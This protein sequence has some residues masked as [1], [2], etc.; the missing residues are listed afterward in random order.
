MPIGSPTFAAYA[1]EVFIP[2]ICRN[3]QVSPRVDIVW[4][5]HQD[6]SLKTSA[7]N[8]RGQ[9]VRRRVLPDSIVPGN[10]QSF[11]SVSENKE[12][13]FQ[14]LAIES[15]IQVKEGTLITTRGTIVLSNSDE[16]LSLLSPCTQ[17]EVDTRM[18]FT[19]PPCS[20]FW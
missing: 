10:W 17:E 7:R 20:P 15:A 18:F 16:D 12:E 9:G 4:E 5:V 8:K 2:F 11:L 13:L 6:N 3:L 14:F 19:C 1:A